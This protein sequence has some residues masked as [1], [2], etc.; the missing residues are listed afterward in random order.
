MGGRQHA[1]DAG[2]GIGDRRHY[3]ADAGLRHR[4]RSRRPHGLSRLIYAYASAAGNNGSAFAG[5]AA[6]DSWQCIAIGLAMLLGRFGYIIPV[7]AIAGQLARAP[8]QG[9]ERRDFPVSGPLFI[10]LLIVTVLLMGVSPSCRCW[11]WAR[12]RNT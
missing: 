12:W 6:A 8:R 5:F 7:L 10:T 11:R 4:H 1:G 9:D 3:P 2:R